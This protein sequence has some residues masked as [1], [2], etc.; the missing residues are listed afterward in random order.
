MGFPIRGGVSVITGAAQGIG[1]A[2]ALNLAGEGADLALVDVDADRLA[3]TA[4]AAENLGVAVSVHPLDIGD[5]AA[6]AA[7][8]DAVLARHGRVNL[9][10][11]NA[12]VALMGNFDEVSLADIEWLFAI[13]FWGVVRMTKA[14]LPVLRREPAAWIVNLSS[15]FGIIAPAGQSAYAASKFAVRGFS[16]A[17]RHELDGSNV[18][19]SVVHPGG[20]ATAIAE[21]ARVA[22]SVDPALARQAIQG[23]KAVARTT[24]EAAAA[25][26]VAGIVRHEK[27]ILIGGDAR[28]IAVMQRFF[29]IN[30]WKFFQKSFRPR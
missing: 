9:L 6:V 3:A 23:F 26:I 22:A 12:G 14:F 2:L 27:R 28:F 18:G 30:Y 19:L 24:P 17:L 7:L 25:R 13:N 1:R 16:E 20:I 21:N 29:P 10:V 15:V 11:N 4:A 8:P 5:E